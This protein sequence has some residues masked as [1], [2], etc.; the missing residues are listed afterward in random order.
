MVIIKNL[1]DLLELKKDQE[2]IFFSK[3]ELWF[4]QEIGTGY[5]HNN[6]RF[7]GNNIT[8]STLFTSKQ[9]EAMVKEMINMKPAVKKLY[10]YDLM[11]EYHGFFYYDNQ[12]MPFVCRST[13]NQVNKNIDD[14]LVASK[15]LAII[16]KLNNQNI[17]L[18]IVNNYTKNHS[19][20]SLIEKRLEIVNPKIIS[21]EELIKNLSEKLSIEIIYKRIP[22]VDHTEPSKELLLQ[23]ISFLENDFKVNE[24]MIHFHCHGGKGRT[25][26]MG[27]IADMFFKAKEGLL[28]NSSFQS[29]VELQASLG[30]SDLSKHSKKTCQE[31]YNFLEDLYNKLLVIEKVPVQITPALKL[32]FTLDEGPL[33]DLNNDALTQEEIASLTYFYQK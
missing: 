2:A 32:L 23:T 31:R 26:S 3:K 18:E 5:D 21:E 17:I 25:T 28:H 22:V 10:L 27:L 1:S 8:G 12:Y 14:K 7:M 9:L 13:N 16:N 29:F 20:I 6:F 19:E 4:S 15:E 11:K 30:G 24:D 33:Y